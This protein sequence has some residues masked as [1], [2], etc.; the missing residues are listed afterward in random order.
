MHPHDKQDPFL[1]RNNKDY[2]KCRLEKTVSC[3]S[4]VAVETKVL[5]QRM[6][7]SQLGAWIS[8]ERTGGS[9]IKMNFEVSI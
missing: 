2:K 4:H 6:F 8:G 7:K 9:S 3:T 5:V 1:G